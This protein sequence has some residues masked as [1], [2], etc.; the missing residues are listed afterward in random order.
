MP[1]WDKI[2]SEVQQLPNSLAIV[3]KYISQLSELTKRTTICYMSAFSVIKPPVPQP[4]QSIIDQD[5]QGFMTCS[6]DTQKE[7]LDLIIH[8]PGGDY[9]ATKRIINYLQSIYKYIRVF[10]PHM[11]MSGGTLIACGADEIFMGPYSSLGPTDPQI[12]LDEGYVSVNAIINEFIQAFKEVSTD[13]S[14]ALLWNERL[15]KVPF[16]QLKAIEN[17]RDN[18][19]KYLVE[20]LQKRNCIGKEIETVNGIAE[21]LNGI[22]SSH[23][24]GIPLSCAEKMQLNVK[25]LSKEKELEDLVLSIYHAATIL[26][27]QSTVQKIIIN[28]NKV[29]YIN[30]YGK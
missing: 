12:L 8:T 21:S 5:M 20:L 10:I 9:E 18:S 16:G 13:P 24:E 14:K 7:S 26:F 19:L 1:T 27:Q 6:K 3:E 28:Q 29:S 4:F 15:K 25:D 11:A 17:M 23:G 2:F 30:N 22:H